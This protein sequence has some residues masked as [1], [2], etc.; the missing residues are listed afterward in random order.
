MRPAAEGKK[1]FF[2]RLI[3]FPDGPQL[4]ARGEHLKEDQPQTHLHT[5]GS[6]RR[7]GGSGMVDQTILKVRISV[8]VE[9]HHLWQKEFVQRYSAVLMMKELML[10]LFTSC[11][12]NLNL[13][14]NKQSLKMH[15]GKKAVSKVECAR[16]YHDPR[17]CSKFNLS[18]TARPCE[19]LCKVTAGTRGKGKGGW[20]FAARWPGSHDAALLH[21]R[22]KFWATSTYKL[23]YRC[24]CRY[25]LAHTQ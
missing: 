24:T 18:Q 8:M 16:E 7:T 19:S 5:L 21:S 2:S 6:W 1:L 4:P 9:Y 15:E 11:N 23:R 17:L 20:G 3:F 25:T 13:K 12:S 14:F 10:D 22:C